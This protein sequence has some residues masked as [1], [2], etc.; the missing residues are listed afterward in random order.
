M[1]R[2]GHAPFNLLKS[3]YPLG[4][5]TLSTSTQPTET[6]HLEAILPTALQ[7]S[8]AERMS[9]M[10]LTTL[11]KNFPQAPKTR[12][13]CVIVPLATCFAQ[14]LPESKNSCVNSM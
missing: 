8:P 5:F 14:R 4:K 6:V 12:C 1:Q 10:Q 11:Q 13:M 2:C 3:V 9:D 7:M